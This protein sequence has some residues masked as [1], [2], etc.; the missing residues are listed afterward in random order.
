MKLLVISHALIQKPAQKR[1]QALAEKYPDVQVR[2]LVPRHWVSTWFIKN[3]E[4]KGEPVREIRFEVVPIKTTNN[5]NWGRYLIRGLAGQ[6]REYRP[7]VIFCIHEEQILQLQQTILYRKLFA[8]KAKLI[9]FSMNAFDRVLRPKNLHPKEVMKFLMT[10]FFWS[11]IKKGTDGALCHFPPIKDQMRKEGY[12]HPILL[13]TQIGVDNEVF[14]PDT[15]DR[16]AMREK[17]GLQGFV[18]GFTGRLIV[19][20]GVLDL[21]KACENAPDDWELLFV[22][23][24]PCKTVIEEWAKNNHFEN[25]VY[26]TGYV[27][28]NEVVRYMRAMDVFVL[29]SRTTHIWI[30]TFPLVVAQA[31]AS[32]VPVVVSSSG[33][34]PYQVGENEG[35]VFN[36]GDSVGLRKQLEKLYQ[37]PDFRLQEAKRLYSRAQ[38][39]FCI[40]AMNSHFHRFITH[41]I[42]KKI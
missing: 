17:L 1:W 14:Q 12:K 39:M 9:Y 37:E 26:M 33:A 36:E 3:V 18:I 35:L 23:E 41:E 22:G 7:D 27:P 11:R 8:P 2:L 10:L 5:R 4:F 42:V 20:K 32:A 6:F 13:Q 34:L 16:A 15:R 21:L 28:V 19:E 38:H 25:R 24:G 40:D 30:D 29:G 31:M